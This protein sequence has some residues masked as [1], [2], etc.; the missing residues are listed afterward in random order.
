M[1]KILV[2]QKASFHNVPIRTSFSPDQ[3]KVY[4]Q[5][6][7]IMTNT[8][9]LLE[10]KEAVLQTAI[11]ILQKL[12]GSAK[13]TAVYEQFSK[14]LG[15]TLDETEA[16]NVYQMLTSSNADSCLVQP[17]GK[18]MYINSS[19]DQTFTLETNEAK[20]G[21]SS[22]NNTGMGEALSQPNNPVGYTTVPTDQSD[23]V[24][25]PDQLVKSDSPAGR[26]AD[27]SFGR[28]HDVEAD[29]DALMNAAEADKDPSKTDRKIDSLAK[30][31]DRD[32]HKADIEEE[33]I[34]KHEEQ[35]SKDKTTLMK[36][37]HKAEI[38]HDEKVIDREE[39]REEKIEKE[40]ISE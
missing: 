27:D 14:V 22:V 12:G 17:N 9:N 1:V 37:L 8:N 11:E 7:T 30:K 20:T 24:V 39:A 40:I 6:V 32:E 28:V 23:A 34:K 2:A 25:E 19:N 35:I 16:N 36:D 15:R 38:R 26:L 13:A 18:C 21:A 33:R 31:L 4:T 5:E 29:A 10:S 3:H